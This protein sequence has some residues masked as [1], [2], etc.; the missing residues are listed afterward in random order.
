MNKQSDLTAL[1]RSVVVE[2]TE[3]PPPAG[4]TLDTPIAELGIDSISVAEITVRIEDRL[5]IEVPASKWL[6]A[7]T[8]QEFVEMI[9][10]SLVP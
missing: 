1:L 6:H 9:E 5:G 10:Q 7:R 4:T 2:V 8:L 3:K